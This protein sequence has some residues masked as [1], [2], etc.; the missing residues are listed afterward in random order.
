VGTLNPGYDGKSQGDG[1]TR[2]TGHKTIRRIPRKR[3]TER[4]QTRKEETRQRQQPRGK[5][6]RKDSRKEN[7]QAKPEQHP[8]AWRTRSTTAPA[9][10]RVCK[11][12]RGGLPEVGGTTIDGDTTL[13]QNRGHN[14][15]ERKKTEGK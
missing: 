10:A 6:T 9:G 3:T 11:N 13:G 8:K 7:T 2:Q 14:K 5:R 12:A 15:E 1:K 4:E